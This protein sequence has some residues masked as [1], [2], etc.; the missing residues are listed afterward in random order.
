VKYLS[1]NTIL[2]RTAIYEKMLN[3]NK[4]R[5]IVVIGPDRVTGKKTLCEKK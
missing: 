1:E 3:F 4:L 5:W 2:V